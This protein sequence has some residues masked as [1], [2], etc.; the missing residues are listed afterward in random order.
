M[1][2]LARDR[3]EAPHLRDLL[4]VR[5][6]KAE[7]KGVGREPDVSLGFLEGVAGTYGVLCHT[8]ANP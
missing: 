4:L 8:L 5:G 1:L 6:R 7:V 3:A 2:G